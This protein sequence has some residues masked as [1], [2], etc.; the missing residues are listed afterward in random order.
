MQ[1]ND[2]GG[3]SDPQTITVRVTNA[4]EAPTITS[5]GGGNAASVNAAENQTAVTTVVADDVDGDTVSF[6]ITGGADAARFGID[7]SSGALTFLTAP[8]F[9]TPGDA[10]GDNQFVV[11][12]QASDG[13]GGT[14]IQTITVSVTNANDAPTITSDGG[15]ANAALNIAEETTAVTTVTANDRSIPVIA[16]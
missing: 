13:N 4:N 7:S 8:D 1:A 11:T 9:E 10:D 12:V 6:S 2:A 16:G 14:D 5:N 15:G 3:L